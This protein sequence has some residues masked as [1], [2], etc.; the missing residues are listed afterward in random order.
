MAI[1]S[2]TPPPVI[3][4]KVQLVTGWTQKINTKITE[5][6]TLLG[7]ATNDFWNN[8]IY[9]PQVMAAAWGTNGADLFRISG[10]TAAYIA[11]VTGK[12]RL[13]LPPGWTFVV[14]AD[15]TVTLTP[16]V[17]APPVTPPAT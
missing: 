9:T 1:I 15:G 8:P 14:N 5:L 12:P 3:D 13:I 16:P 2:S 6:N 7:A 10:L 11:A 17:V 4:P